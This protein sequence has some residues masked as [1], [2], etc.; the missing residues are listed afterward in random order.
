[1]SKDNKKIGIL[2]ENWKDVYF[3]KK[4][5]ALC[6][7]KTGEVNLKILKWKVLLWIQYNLT[8]QM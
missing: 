4:I 3:P 8:M 6:S 1:M 2:V 5:K 7:H